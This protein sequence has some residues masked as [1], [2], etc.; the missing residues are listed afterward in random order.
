MIYESDSADRIYRDA[1][2]KEVI[3]MSERENALK[4]QTDRLYDRI[5]SLRAR[6][7]RE[8]HAVEE[9]GCL[10]R[11]LAETETSPEKRDAYAEILEVLKR[12]AENDG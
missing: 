1:L 8:Q 7:I 10:V 12:G 9:A 3:G 11:K 4:C 2:G 6:L 5:E